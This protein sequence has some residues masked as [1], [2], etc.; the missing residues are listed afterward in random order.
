V[1]CEGLQG[2]IF[3]QDRPQLSQKKKTPKEAKAM[4][5]IPLKFYFFPTSISQYH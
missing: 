2:Q 5:Y 3:F 1:Q 4:I